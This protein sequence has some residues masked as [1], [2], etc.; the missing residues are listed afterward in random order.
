VERL[1]GASVG[2]EWVADLAY[3]RPEAIFVPVCVVKMWVGLQ[4]VLVIARVAN[5]DLGNSVINK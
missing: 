5:Y 1:K 2:N 4:L 3:I